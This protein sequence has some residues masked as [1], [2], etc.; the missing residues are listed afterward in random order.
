MYSHLPLYFMIIGQP[1]ITM[2]LG[3]SLNI[4]YVTYKGGGF[5]HKKL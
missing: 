1:H 3:R 4:I 5:L 2:S